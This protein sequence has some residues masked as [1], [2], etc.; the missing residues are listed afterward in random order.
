MDR[1]VT[2][3]DSLERIAD[4]AVRS[5][6]D[7]SRL[8]P[9]AAKLLLRTP[10]EALTRSFATPWE[11]ALHLNCDVLPVQG[12]PGSGKSYAGARKILA[13]HRQGRKV[14]VCATSHAVIENL[15]MAVHAASQARATRFHVL[16]TEHLDRCHREESPNG[17]D[18]RNL[19]RPIRDALVLVGETT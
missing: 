8:D 9:L 5:Q 14:G 15:L 1:F 7:P 3:P 2:R 16:A 4:R 17:S 6:G 11:I 12:P 18:R 10:S 13:L 19:E